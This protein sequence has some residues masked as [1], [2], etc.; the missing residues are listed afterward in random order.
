MSRAKRLVRAA[1]WAAVVA[2]FPVWFA[3]FLVVPFLPIATAAKAVAAAACIA[4][5]EALFWIG[6]F[7]LGAE[8]IAKFRAPKVTTGVSFASK[9]VAVIGATGGLGSAVARAVAR[10]GGEVVLIAR[11]EEKLAAL[12][13]ALAA[14]TIVSD[15]RPASLREAA[16]ACGPVDHVVCATGADVRRALD[17]HTDEDVARQLD[18]ALAGPVHVARAFLS[19]VRA[20]GTIAL[21]GGFADGSLSLP[22]YSANVAARAGLAGFVASVNRELAVER[23]TERL[24]YVC[25]APADTESERPFAA[26]W[27]RMGSAVV[28]PENVANFVLQSLLGKRTLA[29]MGASTRLLVCLQSLVPPVVDWLVVR[30]W[31]PLLKREFSPSK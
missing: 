30:R 28:A 24:C 14:K 7:V 18:V 31:G 1:A 4:T 17:E 26:L 25:P 11:D 23:R 2:S 15:L 21:F 6:G 10:E 8:V 19:L 3:A 22:Y 9:R 29:V 12:G 27:R 16:A 13:E 20:G 5:G